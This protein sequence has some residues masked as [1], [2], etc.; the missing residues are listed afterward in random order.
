MLSSGGLLLLSA[1][2]GY[3]VLERADSHKGDLRRVGKVVGWVVIVSSLIG[4]ACR[5]WAVSTGAAGCPMA[6]CPFKKTSSQ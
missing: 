5:V 1:A 2:A 3:W 4:L 6:I